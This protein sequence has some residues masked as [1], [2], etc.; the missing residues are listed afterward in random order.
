MLIGEI[1]QKTIF[2]FKNV[3][4]Y[5][6][7]VNA[8]DVDYDSEDVIFTGWDNKLN[9]PQFNIVKRSGYGERTKETKFS[10]SFRYQ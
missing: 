7:F 5:E 9:T 10:R 4:D 3:A 8:I 6:T 1:D 2:R